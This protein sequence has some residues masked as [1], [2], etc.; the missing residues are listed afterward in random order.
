MNGYNANERIN[1]LN[2]GVS[3]NFGTSLYNDK[4]Q[5][6]SSDNINKE[7]SYYSSKNQL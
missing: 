6:Q 2:L 3:A 5:L 1:N 7:D 4:F